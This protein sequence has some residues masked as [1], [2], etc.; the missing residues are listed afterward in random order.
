MEEIHHR[1]SDLLNLTHTTKKY[2]REKHNGAAPQQEEQH[3]LKKHND[4]PWLHSH[5][6]GLAN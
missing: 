4:H 5:S 2:I 6:H 1:F 3:M